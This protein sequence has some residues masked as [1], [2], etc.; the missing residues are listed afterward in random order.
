MGGRTMDW[1]KLIIAVLQGRA[2]EFEGCATRPPSSRIPK[3]QTRGLPE[4]R[5]AAASLQS[6]DICSRIRKGSKLPIC[7]MRPR[8]ADRFQPSVA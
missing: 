8:G 1:R 5:S 4:L 2:G 6:D 3:R 7:A